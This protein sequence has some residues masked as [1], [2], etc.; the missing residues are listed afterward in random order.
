MMRSWLVFGGTVALVA[1]CGGSSGSSPDESGLDDGASP[2]LGPGADAD[3]KTTS[4]AEGDAGLE[5]E[6]ADNS[7][8]DDAT[9]SSGGGMNGSDAA[10][11][12]VSDDTSEQERPTTQNPDDGSATGAADN[13]T[14][15]G[16]DGASDDLDT[17][18]RAGDA[19]T[20]DAASTLG[21]TAEPPTDRGETSCT[22][23]ACTAPCDPGFGVF[24]DLDATRCFAVC[25]DEEI[26]Y[27][28]GI[29]QATQCEVIRG[30]VFVST[31]EP[32]SLSGFPNLRMITGDLDITGHTVVSA[33]FLT[34][35]EGLEKLEVIG[36]ELVIKFNLVLENLDALVALRRVGSVMLLENPLLSNVDGLSGVGIERGVTLSECETL[37]DLR[38]IEGVEGGEV[39]LDSLAADRVRLPSLVSSPKIAAGGIEVEAPNLEQVG[40]LTP[41]AHFVA[42]ELVEIEELTLTRSV[43]PL[44]VPKVMTIGSLTL[45]SSDLESLDAIGLDA[46]QTVQSLTLEDNVELVELG[47]FSNVAIADGVVEIVGNDALV[48]LDGLQGVTSPSVVR[49]NENSSLQNLDA[50]SGLTSGNLSIEE[51]PALGEVQLLALLEGSVALS[52]NASLEAVHLPMLTTTE[53][54]SFWNNPQLADITAPALREVNLQLAVYGSTA[55]TSLAG[56][57]SV[58]TLADLAIVNNEN[59]PPCAYQWLVDLSAMPCWCEGNAESG[60]CE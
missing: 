23:G 49:I 20:G 11:S 35:M 33:N 60:S 26:A 40:T 12:D 51:N 2:A 15:G 53:T 50:L 37:A 29:A 17:D 57:S 13:E 59:L 52:E 10:G 43:P 3:A 41:N 16:G 54:L 6:S 58:Q 24:P 56:F 18:A 5:G 19:G 36:G 7:A 44:E 34:G 47:A 21:D 28:T 55:L 27:D 8:R 48:D 42:P 38:G 31:S 9:D 39:L 45:R 46:L 32:D 22:G 4:S 30:D 14:P 1:A 25:D